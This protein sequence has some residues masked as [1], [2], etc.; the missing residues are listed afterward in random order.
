MNCIWLLLLLCCCGN[1]SCCGNSRNDG[2]GNNNWG[3]GCNHHKHCGNHWN[4]DNWNNRNNRCDCDRD[5]ASVFEN[6]CE[7]DCESVK[8]AK[9]D[10]DDQNCGC[11]KTFP[12]T[13]YPVLDNCD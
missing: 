11:R 12:F 4:S 7:A 3:C 9:N 10:R 2:C 6:V 1:N 13:S 8:D 5:E